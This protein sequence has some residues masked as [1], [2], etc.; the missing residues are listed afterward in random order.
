MNHRALHEVWM[1]ITLERF[2]NE[3]RKTKTKAP[4]LIE[5]APGRLFQISCSRGALN[6]GGAIIRGE[7]LINK[8]TKTHNLF[9]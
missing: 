3:F 6:R 8:L 1:D 9:L 5:Q 7:A 2:S 4:Y